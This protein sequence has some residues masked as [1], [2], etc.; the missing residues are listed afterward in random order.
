MCIATFKNI[1]IIMKMR[2][3][4]I[5]CALLFLKSIFRMK[6]G[7][8]NFLGNIEKCVGFVGMLF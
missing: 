6:K 2:Y 5:L 8:E 7:Y 4:S 1:V 3:R